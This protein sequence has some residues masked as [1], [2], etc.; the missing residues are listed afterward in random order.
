MPCVHNTVKYC[1]FS[2]TFI[3]GLPCHVETCNSSKGAIASNP[4]DDRILI[5]CRRLD[6]FQPSIL[7]PIAEYDIP[8][9]IP[10]HTSC[11]KNRA[12]LQG[13]LKEAPSSVVPAK[14]TNSY[15]RMGYFPCSPPTTCKKKQRFFQ[16]SLKG[17]Q[18][19]TLEGD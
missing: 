2:A 18:K 14:Y 8:P 9:A 15:L 13:S 6:S 3:V 1:C 10:L 16:V 19:G 17:A 12:F 4:V 7:I 5:P 11:E